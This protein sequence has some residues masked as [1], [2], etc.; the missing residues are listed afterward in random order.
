MPGQ[1]AIGRPGVPSATTPFAPI[2]SKEIPMLSTSTTGEP[3]GTSAADVALE[4][5]PNAEFALL[6]PN[7]SDARHVVLTRRGYNLLALWQ[8]ELRLFGREVT[9]S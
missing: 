1:D 6:E 9:A 2:P 3:A 7:G 5:P 4:R 8:A